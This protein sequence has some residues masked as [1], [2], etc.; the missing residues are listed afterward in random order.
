MTITKYPKI[1]NQRK[2]EVL[3]NLENYF[4]LFYCYLTGLKYYINPEI[5]ALINLN[6]KVF[7]K[8]EPTNQ[9]DKHAIEVLIESENNKLIKIGYI[10][11]NE[12]YLLSKLLDN[13]FNL[14]AF[15]TEINESVIN[16]NDFLSSIQIEIYMGKSN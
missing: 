11:K 14:I 1:V 2:K 4:K 7:L 9:F 8:R 10:A 3:P 13:Q 6:Q 12:N 5:N 15:I 16:D